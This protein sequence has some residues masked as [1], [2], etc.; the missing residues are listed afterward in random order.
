MNL[1]CL[2][3]R[4]SSKLELVFP[5]TQVRLLL[6]PSS[7]LKLAAAA[8]AHGQLSASVVV[9]SSLGRLLMVLQQIKIMKTSNISKV[10][11]C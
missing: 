10:L 8:A 2:F 5:A 1:F 4:A 7:G 3:I 11:S 6:A 9:S